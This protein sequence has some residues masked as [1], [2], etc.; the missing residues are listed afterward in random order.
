MSKPIK[1]TAEEAHAIRSIAR[2]HRPAGIY[3]K[4]DGNTGRAPSPEKVKLAR[5]IYK[6]IRK[7]EG[8]ERKQWVEWFNRLAPWVVYNE[9]H[10]AK[11]MG[12]KLS[13]E[14]KRKAWGNW[15]SLVED[16]KKG[17]AAKGITP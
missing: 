3:R 7:T 5:A 16:A 13:Q 10:D 8:H 6:V 12:E 9:L 15:P 2:G 14:E 4:E 11:L 17:L 1:I